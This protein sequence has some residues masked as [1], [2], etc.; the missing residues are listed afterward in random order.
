MK[1]SYLQ[2]RH[3]KETGKIFQTLSLD[4][5]PLTANG[6]LQMLEYIRQL[7][8]HS[9]SKKMQETLIPCLP[10]L[11]RCLQDSLLLYRASIEKANS[12]KKARA[13]SQLQKLLS[14]CAPSCPPP[15]SILDWRPVVCTNNYNQPF[16]LTFASKSSLP[17]VPLRAKTQLAQLFP[18]WF[19][20]LDDPALP[21]MPIATHQPLRGSPTRTTT[22]LCNRECRQQDVE[23]YDLLNASA[24]A[25]EGQRMSYATLFVLTD[26]TAALCP[27]V[28]EEHLTQKYTLVQELVDI[29]C[30]VYVQEQEEQ[31][32]FAVYPQL[33]WLLRNLVTEMTSTD[34]GSRSGREQQ[35]QKKRIKRGF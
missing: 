22:V 24:F 15:I 20:T 14:A 19:S 21:P 12:E 6:R 3:Y 25:Q 1:R 33:I 35:Q 11:V 13:N 28:V 8:Y 34:E 5:M 16:S 18:V 10:F 26:I 27:N 7:A 29:V 23:F 4:K 2:D 31:E 9:S 32:C 17:P 30:K